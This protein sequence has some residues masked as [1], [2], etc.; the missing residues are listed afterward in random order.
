VVTQAHPSLA[1]TAAQAGLAAQ[2][3]QAGLDVLVLVRTSIP[4]SVTVAQAQVVQL[5]ET[6][7]A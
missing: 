4:L 1:V 6:T 3:A 2:A 5:V 7:W